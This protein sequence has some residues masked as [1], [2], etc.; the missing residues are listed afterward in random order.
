MVKI[1]NIFWCD[2]TLHT[3]IA[4]GTQFDWAGTAE[5]CCAFVSFHSAL[6]SSRPNRL[7]DVKQLQ[8]LLVLGGIVRSDH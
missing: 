7:E 4:L 3:G 8:H 6:N 2:I 5:K 1:L